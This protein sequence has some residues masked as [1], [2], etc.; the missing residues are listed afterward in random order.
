MKCFS[1]HLDTA[2]LFAASVA[3]VAFAAE[4]ITG[5]RLR[6]DRHP[7]FALR[8]GLLRRPPWPEASAEMLAAVETAARA[9]EAAGASMTEIV[10]PPI[11]ADAFQAHGTI[12]D[13][14]AF[15]SLAFE[16]DHHRGRLGPRLRELLDQAARV[17]PEAYD[18]ARRTA[19]RARAA[20]ASLF[21]QIE[22]IL[23]PSAPGAAPQGL[24]STGASTF[25]RLWTLMGAPCVNVA[26]LA[27][28][29]GLP[30]GVQ[31]VGRFGSDE[32]TLAA[33]RFVE[34]AITR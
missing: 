9:A 14:E 19:S 31:I 25:N 27:D 20:F 17:T 23:T 29:T 21:S 5:R 22:V 13:C 10:L 4:A 15:Q 1:W 7:P 26:G 3:D 8:L 24:G 34:S 33:A 2:G 18:S 30:L 16:Y 6:V 12:Q 28:A 11:F 32:A